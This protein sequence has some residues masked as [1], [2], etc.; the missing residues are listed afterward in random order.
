VNVT[1]KRDVFL[2]N[3]LP[4]LGSGA[5]VG[6]GIG[7]DGTQL[8]ASAGT[9]T[10]QNL[11]VTGNSIGT[12]GQG[13]GIGVAGSCDPAGCT[14]LGVELYDSS[15]IGNGAPSGPGIWGQTGVTLTLKNAIVAAGSGGST[16]DAAGF[17]SGTLTVRYSDSCT[18][19]GFTGGPY[20]GAGNICS[21]PA[22]QR[23]GNAASVE[24]TA[25]SPTIDVGSNSM[26]PASVKTDYQGATRIV[27]G[28]SDTIATVDMGA[29][30][31]PTT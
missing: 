2:D 18:G 27:D 5:S 11:A 30:E 29:D 13:G 10:G 4:A 22:L 15:V 28:N 20:S 16:A 9:F 1:S 26:I 12:N 19:V 7:L 14:P 23:V 25:L 21:D 3:A 24:E 31:R 6:A 8:G 17:D